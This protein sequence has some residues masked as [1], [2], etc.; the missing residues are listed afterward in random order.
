MT[1][2][3]QN[4]RQLKSD[5]NG[6]TLLEV[7]AALALLSIL[8]SAILGVF[9]SGVSIFNRECLQANAQ[10]DARMAM[11]N[12]IADIRECKNIGNLKP[13]AYEIRD[14]NNLPITSGTPIISGQPMRLYLEKTEAIGGIDQDC[15][16]LY[17]VNTQGELF[18]Q[19]RL[20]PSGVISDSYAITVNKVNA[21]FREENGA[22]VINIVILDSKNNKLF[23]LANTCN[24]RID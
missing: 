15:T 22:I 13:A 17:F 6:L 8:A 19:R 11:D 3:I 5:V 1:S 21:T 20:F 10:Y 16:V 24:P 14:N 12:I 23:E 4:T 9:S 2:L 18:R 7:L